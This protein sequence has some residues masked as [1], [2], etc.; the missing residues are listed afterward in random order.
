MHLSVDEKRGGV[1]RVRG[2][3]EP[4]DTA[5]SES[6]VESLSCKQLRYSYSEN[7]WMCLPEDTE[8]SAYNTSEEEGLTSVRNCNTF[9]LETWCG[10]RGRTGTDT[11]RMGPHL[12]ELQ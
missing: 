9:R 8:K 6:D 1:D 4:N 3:P 10:S 5:Y 7:D 11:V 2:S 12:V